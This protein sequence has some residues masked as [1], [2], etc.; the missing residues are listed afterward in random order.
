LQDFQ[1]FFI[2]V[3]TLLIAAIFSAHFQPNL[4]FGCKYLKHFP[5]HQ[6]LSLSHDTQCKISFHGC[7]KKHKIL[8]KTI[9]NNLRKQNNK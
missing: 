4:T 1:G 5:L 8:N 2:T 7:I 6:T 3:E 9:W